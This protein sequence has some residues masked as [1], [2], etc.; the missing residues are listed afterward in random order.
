M[1]AP[2]HVSIPYQIAIH[3]FKKRAKQNLHTITQDRAGS[4]FHRETQRTLIK[5]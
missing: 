5:G 2:H 1:A 4:Q 3:A